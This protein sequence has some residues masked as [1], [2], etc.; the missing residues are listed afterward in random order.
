M[1]GRACFGSETSRIRRNRRGSKGGGAGAGLV[2]GLLCG[3]AAP[4]VA[5]TAVLPGSGRYFGGATENSAVP[6]AAPLSSW[7]KKDAASADGAAAGFGSGDFSSSPLGSGRYPATI[8]TSSDM[9]T[10]PDAGPSFQT[11]PA[12]LLTNEAGS[13]SAGAFAPAGSAKQGAGAAPISSLA[14]YGT[15]AP[16]TIMLTA[17]AGVALLITARRPRRRRIR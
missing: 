7:M 10:E 5:A 15:P 11:S 14:D 17:L 12:A 8:L 2:L 13:R 6:S 16:T 4:A 1:N 3:L 9:L